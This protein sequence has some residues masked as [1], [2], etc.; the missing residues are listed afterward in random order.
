M[1]RPFRPWSACMGADR[2]VNRGDTRSGVFS[3]AVSRVRAET[4]RS[5]KAVRDILLRVFARA[6]SPAFGFVARTG[7]GAEHCLDHGFLPV[8]RHFYQPI[9]EPRDLP[10]NHWTQEDGLE[11]VDFGIER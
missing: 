1:P 11:G 6:F 10:S 4:R 8:P 7:V 9:F 5:L 2:R 3:A